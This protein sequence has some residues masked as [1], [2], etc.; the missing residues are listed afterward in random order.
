[1]SFKLNNLEKKSK[2]YGHNGDLDNNFNHELLFN[3]IKSKN[4][5]L[6]TYNNCSYIKNLYKDYIILEV[7]WRYGM[8]SN[9]QSSEIV[10][11]SKL[12]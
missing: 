3:T 9:K 10:I 7:N 11:L 5:W 6:L 2:L 12:T 8:N 4:N 1:M